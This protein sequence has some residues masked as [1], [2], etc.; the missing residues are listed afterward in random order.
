MVSKTSFKT[1]IDGNPQM[2]AGIIVQTSSCLPEG[3][4][5]LMTMNHH[6][7]PLNHHKI[8]LNLIKSHEIN[9]SFPHPTSNPSVPIVVLQRQGTSV[10]AADVPLA[11]WGAT[12]IQ[13]P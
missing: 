11:P 1:G 6:Q 8:Q 12:K 5:H 3:K 7:I 13:G 4:S 2:M 10:R 9:Q